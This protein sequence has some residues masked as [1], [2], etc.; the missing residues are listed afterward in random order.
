MESIS[1]IFTDALGFRSKL[2]RLACDPAGSRASLVMLD[3]AALVPVCRA[4]RER[5]EGELRCAGMPYQDV[6]NPPYLD[7][8]LQVGTGKK[9][10]DVGRLWAQDD[11]GG[12]VI[13]QVRLDVEAVLRKL[14]YWGLHCHNETEEEAK[15]RIAQTDAAK[16]DEGRGT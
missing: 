1:S 15:M 5:G 14:D 7:C 9:R 3:P 4:L 12:R 8:T 16:L 10:E 2:G 6:T 11:A 13:Y